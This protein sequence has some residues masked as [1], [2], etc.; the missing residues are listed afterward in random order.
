ME[1]LTGRWLSVG[2][3]IV[4]ITAL[5]TLVS[6]LIVEGAS[7]LFYITT[8]ITSFFILV[9]ILSIAVFIY[10]F[11]FREM[12]INGSGKDYSIDSGKESGKRGS[13]SYSLYRDR[14][15]D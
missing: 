15:D 3:L 10:V 4:A 1:I 12:E 8:F 5:L 9:I 2:I 11:F 13:G 14:E 6:A 7:L